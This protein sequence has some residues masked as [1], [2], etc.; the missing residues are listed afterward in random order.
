MYAGA[1]PVAAAMPL[2][3]GSWWTFVPAGAL[4]IGLVV[5]MLCEE[6]LL[7]REL[8]G[9]EEYVHRTRYRLLPGIW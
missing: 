5:R 8:S 9:Y 3:P 6:A 1:I 7:Q 4:M 2:L